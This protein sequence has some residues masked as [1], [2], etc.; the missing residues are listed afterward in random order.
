MTGRKNRALQVPLVV[1]YKALEKFSKALYG[2]T[3][4]TSSARFF[5]P[6]MSCR[7]LLANASFNSGSRLRA[8]FL[9]KNQYNC[10][11]LE[12]TCELSHAYILER[13][14]KIV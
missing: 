1:P 13:K 14:F 5:R 10:S 11:I 4:G 8:V 7:E 6:V 12:N 9:T 3:G 2:V